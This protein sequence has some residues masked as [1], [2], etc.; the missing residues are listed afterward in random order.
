MIEYE[1]KLPSKNR[2]VFS[3][4]THTH[5]PRRSRPEHLALIRNERR[6]AL[7]PGCTRRGAMQVSVLTIYTA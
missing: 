3:R 7:S 5:G 2:P 4:Y 6:L 1:N